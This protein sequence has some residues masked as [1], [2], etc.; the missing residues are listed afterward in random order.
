MMFRDRKVRKLLRDQRPA[1]SERLVQS[2]RD[3]V[4][5]APVRAPRRRFALAAVV[6][7]FIVVL[8]SAF[9][10]LGYAASGTQQAVVAVKHVVA[11]VKQHRLVTVQHTAAHSQYGHHKVT[12]CHN[13][14]PIEIDE[15]ALPAHL[16]HGDY[17]GPCHGGSGHH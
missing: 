2:I 6:P 15:A 8:L 10:G 17:L 12:I 4:G 3:E 14:H 7:V 5:T 1:P 11:P 9:G 16:A 13:G